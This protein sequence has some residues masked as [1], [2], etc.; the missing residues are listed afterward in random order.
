MF[1]LWHHFLNVLLPD[2]CVLCDEV[3]QPRPLDLLCSHC[4]QTLPHNSDSCAAC[5]MPG[6]LSAPACVYCGHHHHSPPPELTLAALRHEHSARW[7]VHRLKF[8]K[9]FRECEALA[10]T[11]AAQVRRLYAGRALPAL[12]VPVPLSWRNQAA[13]GYNQA[14]CLAAA[15]SR[16]LHI[17]LAPGLLRRQHGQA[18]RTLSRRARQR[19]PAGTFTLARAPAA[20]PIPGG[21]FPAVPIPAG[22]FP[23]HAALVDD[24]LT[25]GRTTA[26]IRTLLHRHGV[27]RVDIWTA[28]RAV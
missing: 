3:L 16:R 5:A 28:S 21:L 24:V 2:C 23:A 15:L 17:P 27:P 11:M 13:R 6:Q 12:L 4:R 7:L 9:G 1:S 26:V 18:Q 20:G 19:L 10:G 8:Q 22:P 14:A 25:T